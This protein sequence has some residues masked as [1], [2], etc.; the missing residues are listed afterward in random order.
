MH[1]YL[2]VRAGARELGRSPARMRGAGWGWG[3]SW[4]S[5]P[6]LPEAHQG[7]PRRRPAGRS[8]GFLEAKCGGA[9]GPCGGNPG[10]QR[11]S[12]PWPPTPRRG[13]GWSWCSPPGL[14]EARQGSPRRR[15]AG[16]SSGF[17]EAKCVGARGLRGGNPGLQLESVPW[18]PTPRRGW[19]CGSPRVGTW[20]GG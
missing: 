1:I 3:W 4:C 13:W 10:L 8:S 18:P 7:S 9:R 20:G 16:W 12:V 14:P 5:P 15:P 11:E 19:G 6:G 17:L 2:C